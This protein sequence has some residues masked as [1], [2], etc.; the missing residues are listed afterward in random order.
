[1]GQRGGCIIRVFSTPRV[2]EHHAKH[3]REEVAR[4]QFLRVR[5]AE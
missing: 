5:S 1:L 4:I 2:P 3:I